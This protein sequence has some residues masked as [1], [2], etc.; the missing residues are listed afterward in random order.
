MRKSVFKLPV[1]LVQQ[2]QIHGLEHE[3]SA[4][5]SSAGVVDSHMP[6]KVGLVS[7]CGC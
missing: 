5:A 3:R 2:Q 1:P 4:A 6:G 7:W